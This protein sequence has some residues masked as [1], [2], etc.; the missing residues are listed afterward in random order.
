MAAQLSVWE[1]HWSPE[2]GGGDP[3]S[4]VKKPPPMPVSVPPVPPVPLPFP[5]PPVPKR[6]LEVALHEAMS[7]AALTSE[8]TK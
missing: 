8:R 4:F 5:V 1:T 2:H 3:A 6:V 7:A